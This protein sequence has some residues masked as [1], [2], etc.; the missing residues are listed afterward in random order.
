[1][2]ASLDLVDLG[3]A[4]PRGLGDEVDHAPTMLAT[5]EWL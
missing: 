2:I 3:V 5:A 4:L 1:M